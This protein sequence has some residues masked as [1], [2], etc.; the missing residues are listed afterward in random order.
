M[1][2]ERKRERRKNPC[3]VCV[4][5]IFYLN[6]TD[7]KLHIQSGDAT[8]SA[9]YG[10][11]RSVSFGLMHTLFYIVCVCEMMETTAKVS[12]C[13][14]TQWEK[15]M[16]SCHLLYLFL[17]QNAGE[18]SSL[19]TVHC[20]QT[21]HCWTASLLLW[22]CCINHEG[23][24]LEI[25]YFFIERAE[26]HHILNKYTHIYMH[27]LHTTGANFLSIFFFF[28]FRKFILISL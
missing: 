14:K 17:Q 26:W 16:Q 23:V 2:K 10:K 21:L 7:V 25:F 24:I 19:L 1:P 22:L 27:T 15:T 11:L 4:V 18:C 20:T 8:L 28:F 13:F 5:L 9:H 3:S 12:H 6:L